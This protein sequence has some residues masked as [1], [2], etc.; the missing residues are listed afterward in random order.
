MP[1]QTWIAINQVQQG[2]FSI[3][4]LRDKM[5][6]G[7]I[8]GLTLYWQEGM[9]GWHEL[10]E[11]NEVFSASP[12]AL[13][14]PLSNFRPA[15]TSGRA[16][17]AGF[18]TNRDAVA[19]RQAYLN[20]EAGVRSI[21]TLYYIGAFFILLSAGA[22]FA[23][24]LGDGRVP[25]PPAGSMAFNVMIAVFAIMAGL[26]IW[27]GRL[28]RTLSPSVRIPGTI[29]AVLGLISFPIGTAINAYVLY[30]IHSAK[31]KFVFS[32]EYQEVVAA[33]PQIK[34][35]TSILVKILVGILLAFFL[36]AI[37]GGVIEGMKK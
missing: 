33:T 20:H 1:D 10:R 25:L 2:P 34:Y 27:I 6:R 24:K 36:L 14:S 11:W 26:S 21:G 19:L 22:A 35:K 3:A 31:G 4:E 7:E 17:A 29:L 23:G 37:V 18:G 9:S 13:P 30:L 8:N 5:A 15:E 12:Q 32:D 16:P 28:Y